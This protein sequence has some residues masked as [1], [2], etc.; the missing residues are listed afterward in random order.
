MKFYIYI[1]HSERTKKYYIGQT[2]NLIHRLH[3]HNTGR[4]LS[5]KAGRPW[6]I[7]YS[8]NFAFRSEAVQ[9]ER[10]LKSPKGWLDLRSIKEHHRN[11]AQPG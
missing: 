10:F 2:N 9:R 8:E 4:N 11:V 1:L 3:Y 6:K 5:T 7:I